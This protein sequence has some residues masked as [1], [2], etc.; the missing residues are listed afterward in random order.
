MTG[1]QP[2]PERPYA[3]LPLE[4]LVDQFA[5]TRALDAAWNPSVNPHADKLGELEAE[6]LARYEKTPAKKTIIAVG[7][8]FKVPISARRRERKMK[9]GALAKILVKLGSKKFVEICSV[10]LAALEKALGKD[11]LKAFVTDKLSGKRT[12]GE[13][14][15]IQEGN[16]Q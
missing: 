14:V 1:S 11:A 4:Q 12:V 7:H 10:T 8:R 13:P 15:L 2:Q 6:L 3:K 5:E 16:P 9:A